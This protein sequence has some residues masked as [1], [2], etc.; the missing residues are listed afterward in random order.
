MSRGDEAPQ[1]RTLLESLGGVDV[2]HRLEEVFYSHVLRDPVLSE[3]FGERRPPR[4]T[5]DPESE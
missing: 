5:L 1:E 2:V 4:W 3:L